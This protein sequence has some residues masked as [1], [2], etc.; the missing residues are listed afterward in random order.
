MQSLIGQKIGELHN[1]TE[2]QLCTFKSHTGRMQKN[3]KIN[4][5]NSYLV[6]GQ[7]LF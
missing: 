2:H 4:E 7:E 5:V 1:I 3:S 6:L